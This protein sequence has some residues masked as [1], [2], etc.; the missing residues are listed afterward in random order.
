[1]LVVIQSVSQEFTKSGAEFRKV[2]GITGDG[3]PIIKNVFDNLQDKWELLV[4]NATLEFTME[5]KGQFWNVIDVKKPELPPPQKP[6]EAPAI[7][8]P[9][10]P[11]RDLAIEAQVAI[12]SI[13]E[14]FIAGK[15][16]ELVTSN[17][18]FV[19]ALKIWLAEKLNPYMMP[20]QPETRTVV[21]GPIAMV[22]PSSTEPHTFPL[23]RAWAISL[24]KN[25]TLS[26]MVN[27]VKIPEAELRSDP[28]GA[29]H[30]IKKFIEKE[31]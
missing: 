5:K 31:E 17:N 7:I 1:M 20:Q 6:Y 11:D 26:W 19:V 25:Y 4:E 10:K 22:A 2:I 24:N 18:P 12:K 29:Y 16:E 30:K 23:L 9:A 8:K 13:T 21:S 27:S 28:V 15:I 14:I 3:K